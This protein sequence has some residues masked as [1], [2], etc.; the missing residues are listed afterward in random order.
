MK[1]NMKY[2]FTFFIL[3]IVEIIIALFVHDTIIR[4]YIGDILVIILMYT[5]IRGFVKKTIKFLP[6]YLFV[7]A[8]I[9]EISQYYHI[10]NILHLQ[11]NKIMSIII[12]TSFDIQDILSYLVATVILVIWDKI[13][14]SNI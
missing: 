14:K 8:A 3:F 12:G 13:V 2:I 6:V 7:F 1:L 9:V 4:P 5:F 10:V 11:N